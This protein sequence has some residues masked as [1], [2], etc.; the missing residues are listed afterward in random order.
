MTETAPARRRKVSAPAAAPD[1]VPQLEFDTISHES[2]NALVA[3]GSAYI[4]RYT[5]IKDD[6]TTLLR[7]IAVTMVALR[8][9]NTTS[10]G[11]TDWVGRGA[12]YRAR[13][14][15]L[16]ADAGIGAEDEDTIRQ[17]VR[18]HIGVILRDVMTPDELAE[19]NLQ[20]KSPVER[21]RA[22]RAER[23]ALVATA[24]ALE[25]APAAP[26]K[27][28]ADTLTIGGAVS[29]Q[30]TLIQPDAI[31]AMGEDERAKLDEELAEA[32]K[33]IA[34]LRRLTRKKPR[35]DA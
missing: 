15:K 18:Y 8:K 33:H 31:G 17:A 3:R 20:E 26:V 6:Q 24:R 28:P 32:Q 13:V 7:N 30:L 23:A 34:R 22:A 9:Q 14:K 4:R 11:K 16:F 35:S 27:S 1:T 19:F 5:Q 21:G 2:E 25:A 29:R 12:E 10:D